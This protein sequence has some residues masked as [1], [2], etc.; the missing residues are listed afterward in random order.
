MSAALGYFVAQHK[1][2]KRVAAPQISY[3]ALFRIFCGGS[4]PSTLSLP[5]NDATIAILTQRLADMPDW[6]WLSEL[7]GVGN[8]ER[9]A[10]LPNIRANKVMLNIDGELQVIPPHSVFRG[11]V[12]GSG[13]QF[14]LVVQKD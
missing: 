4:D 7:S 3:S 10:V 8:A 6:M 9:S 13:A 2:I 14:V 11:T 12:P 1:Q 5:A